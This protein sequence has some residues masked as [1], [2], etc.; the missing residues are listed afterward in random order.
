MSSDSDPQAILEPTRGML[1]VMAVVLAVTAIGSWTKLSGDRGRGEGRAFGTWEKPKVFAVDE[2]PARSDV[3]GV[4]LRPI[5]GF[6]F[7]LVDYPNDDRGPASISLINRGQAILCEITR[8]DD[9][10]T[11]WPPEPSDYGLTVSL[12]RGVGAEGEQTGL[13]V[14][15]LPD[16]RLQV[17]SMLYDQTRVIW[18]SPRKS[19]TWPL[20]L[21]LGK[22]DLGDRTVLIKVYE[23]QAQTAEPDYAS[24]P[25]AEIASAL[26]PL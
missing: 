11:P 7:Y 10:D 17:Q 1:A 8:F 26:F 15:P 19:P 18:A 25:I 6:A 21:H 23:M 5:E 2:G 4:G 20:R 13:G 3:L 16:F 22:C 12:R 9:L 24:G 14:G